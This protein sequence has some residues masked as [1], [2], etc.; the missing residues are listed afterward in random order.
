MATLP[1]QMQPAEFITL[2]QA[3]GVGAAL[4]RVLS[5]LLEA[6]WE[7]KFGE[8]LREHDSSIVALQTS[9]AALE[10][11]NARLRLRA[12]E[13]DLRLDEIE[14]NSRAGSLIIKGLPS[15]SFADSATS[16][17]TDGTGIAA[18]DNATHK[19]VESTVIRFCKER[20]NVE[21]STQDI[22]S[23][24]RM[25]DNKS[26]RSTTSSVRP[27]MI[28]FA[29]RKVRDDIFRAKKKLKATSGDRRS[30]K[31]DHGVFI[32]EN[33]TPAANNLY[34]EARQRLRNKKLYAAWTN[35]GRV[36]VKFVED[37]SERP[38]WV[39]CVRDFK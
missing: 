33:L 20:L 10:A 30:H 19:A 17:V 8:R 26:N 6:S 1:A 16:S 38:T 22:I 7:K 28:N 29:N 5:P 34:Y 13:A 9:H 21:V 37:T 35:N 31:N 12:L 32:S 24:Y 18:M 4:A 14:A 23:A 2:L 36:Y 3:P 11:E 25:K 39:R 27:I 15:G